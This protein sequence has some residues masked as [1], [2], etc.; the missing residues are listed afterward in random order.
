MVW[1]TAEGVIPSRFAAA[2]IEPRETVS[3]K[4]TN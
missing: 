3:A 1:L 2:L 4:T